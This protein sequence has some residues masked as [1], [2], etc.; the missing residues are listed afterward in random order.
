MP[1]KKCQNVKFPKNLVKAMSDVGMQ[2]PQLQYRLH[3]C[4]IVVSPATIRKWRHGRAEPKMDVLAALVKIF[5][6][7]NVDALIFGE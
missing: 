5:D 3:A 6:F 1:K 7:E 4:G 2:S